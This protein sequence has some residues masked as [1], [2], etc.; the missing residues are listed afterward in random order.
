[1]ITPEQVNECMMRYCRKLNELSAGYREV[2]VKPGRKFYKVILNGLGN[3]T[4]RSVH[5]F[6]DKATGDIYKPA[7]WAQ[8][9]KD[10]RYNVV[11]D[12]TRL[13]QVMDQHGS[14]LYK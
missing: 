10:A 8:P 7:S 6:I 11:R 12:L 1:M 14:Y 2:E 13:E 3:V 4:S 5:S 9:A